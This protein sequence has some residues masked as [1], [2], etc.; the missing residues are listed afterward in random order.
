MMNIYVIVRSYPN[1]WAG[2]DIIEAWSDKRIA[3][4]RAEHLTNMAMDT[5]HP[6]TIPEYHVK[7]TMLDRE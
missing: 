2:E 3:K 4:D 7:K 1:S 6:D 5:G